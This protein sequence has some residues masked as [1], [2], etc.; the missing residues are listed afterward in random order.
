MLPMPTLVQP[1]FFQL[2]FAT[3]KQLKY[4]CTLNFQKFISEKRNWLMV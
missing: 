2:F 3:P 1:Y 4:L